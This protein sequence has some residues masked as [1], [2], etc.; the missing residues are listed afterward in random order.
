MTPELPILFLLWA[1]GGR[2]KKGSP[3]HDFPKGKAV[4]VPVKTVPADYHGA[5][6]G[7]WEPYEPLTPWVIS[8]AQSLLHDP[9]FTERVEPDGSDGASG[10]VRFLRTTPSPGHTAVTAWR[11][12]PGVVEPAP[13]ASPGA[14]EVVPVVH[15]PATSPGASEAASA[16]PPG[17]PAVTVRTLRRGMRGADVARWQA[18]LGLPA[19][20]DFGPRTEASTRAFQRA[21]GLV[22]DGVVGPRTWSAVG[23]PS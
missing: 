11:H 1:L 5:A 9:T 23:V 12:R 18:L 7:I 17:A 4:P 21:R 2:G 13:G 20:G 8:R 6:P 19:D 3:R 15:V 22:D 16:P 10:E 14:P